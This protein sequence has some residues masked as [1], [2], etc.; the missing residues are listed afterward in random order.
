MKKYVNS[1]PCK[2][3][4]SLEGLVPHLKVSHGLIAALEDGDTKLSVPDINLPGPVTWV[5]L[6]SGFGHQI[7]LV[8]DKPKAFDGHQH[9]CVIVQQNGSR[10]QAQ[11]FA[12][13]LEL[14]G[15]RRHMTWEATPR[16]IHEGGFSAITNSDCLVS[17]A[18]TAQLLADQGKLKLVVSILMV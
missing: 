12:Y 1:G 4:G 3:Q 15:K 5:E 14:N 10:N 7:I 8:L 2:W 17:K 9:F 16:S 11:N 18:C 6:L 13:R